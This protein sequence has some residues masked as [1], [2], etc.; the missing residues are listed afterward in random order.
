LDDCSAQVFHYNIFAYCSI[1]RVDCKF[2][3]NKKKTFTLRKS[4][5]PDVSINNIQIPRKT[6]IKYLGMTIDSKLTWKQHIIKK[7][8][9]VNITIKQL[10]WLLGR[11]SNLANEYS[12][13]LNHTYLD[14][15]SGIMGLCQ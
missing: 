10:N 9:Q 14:V 1:C 2:T 13:D 8:K 12:Q 4:S 3:R 7:R 15:W 6:E 11:K 5:T